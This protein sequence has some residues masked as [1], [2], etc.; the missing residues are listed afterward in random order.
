M[1]KNLIYCLMPLLLSVGCRST[2]NSVVPSEPVIITNSDSVRVETVIKTVY[3]P[4]EVDVDIPQ[5]SETKTVQCDS[6]HV[7][8]DVAESDAW[9]NEDGTLGHSI[10]N[11]PG[12]LKGNAFVSQITEQMN[13]DVVKFREV[14]VPEPYPVEVERSMTLMEQIKLASFWY[15]LGT[16]LACVGVVFRR[17]ILTVFR[18]ITRKN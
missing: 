4:V 7:E 2:K 18:R 16:T 15:L 9:L 11:K 3:V 5:Q 14:P 17:P 13:K 10:R 12:K 6:S 1:K 8:T